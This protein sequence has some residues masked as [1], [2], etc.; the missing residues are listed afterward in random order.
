MNESTRDDARRLIGGNAFDVIVTD[1]PYGR[2]EGMSKFEG[3][4]VLSHL[5]DVIGRDRSSGKPLLKV[6]GRMVAFQPCRR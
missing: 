4:P 3:M 2:R 1:P 6:G 5:I